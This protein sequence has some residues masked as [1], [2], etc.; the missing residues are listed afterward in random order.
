MIFGKKAAMHIE[1]VRQLSEDDESLRMKC[2]RCCGEEAVLCLPVPQPQDK[3][4]PC[5]A[6]EFGTQ[7]VPH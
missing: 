5:T 6:T 1:E 3:D 4:N 7:S 2:Q